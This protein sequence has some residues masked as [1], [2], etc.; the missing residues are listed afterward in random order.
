MIDETKIMQYADGTLPIEEHE[1][2]KK[3]IETDPKLNEL[4]NTFKETGDLLFKLGNEIKSQPLPKNLQDKADILK[5]WKKSVTKETGS[6]NFFGLF[7]V[8]YAGVAAAFAMFFVGGFYTN[9]FV[10]SL[11]DGKTK[12][13]RMASQ[14]VEAPKDLKFRGMPSADEDLS[15]RVTNL[16]RYFNADQFI[17]DIN[18]KLDTLEVNDEFE[19]SLE[20]NDGKKVK[21]ILVENFDA[22]GNNCKKI[23]FNEPLKLSESDQGTDVTL[24]ICKINNNYEIS[25]INLSK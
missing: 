9:T 3:A 8:Q 10:A 23:A 5:T 17:Q 4:Y 12:T 15:T 13:V 25:S 16:Y 19:S 11:D 7:K 21:F 6:F 24:D 1:E 2:V 20:D 18:S 22:N 14:K